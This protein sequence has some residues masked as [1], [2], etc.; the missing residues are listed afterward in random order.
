MRIGSTAEWLMRGPAVPLV[1]ARRDHVVRRVIACVDGSTHAA[2]AVAALAGMPWIKDCSVDVLAVI[3]PDESVAAAAHESV[4]VLTKAGA[5]ATARIVESEPESWLV[6]PTH[7]IL[8][9][10]EAVRPDL[11]V[12]G[13]RGFTG[14]PRLVLGSVASAVTHAVPC[15]VLLAQA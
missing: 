9:A 5:A 8:D 6:N 11:V 10:V 1:I 12:L 13:T 4:A 3:G 7:L 14:I 15:S 2:A